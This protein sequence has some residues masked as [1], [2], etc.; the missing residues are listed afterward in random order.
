MAVAGYHQYRA[1]WSLLTTWQPVG[2]G[3]SADRW[4]ESETAPAGAINRR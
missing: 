3:F 4:H 2:L 1:V